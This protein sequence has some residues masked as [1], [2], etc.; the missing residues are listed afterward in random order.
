MALKCVMKVLHYFELTLKKQNIFFLKWT[1]H[2]YIILKYGYQ[3][4]L[5]IKQKN[6]PIRYERTLDKRPIPSRIS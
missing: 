3:P 4:K 1:K 5:K 6:K 2:A